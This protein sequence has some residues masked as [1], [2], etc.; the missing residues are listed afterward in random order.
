MYDGLDNLAAG[1]GVWGEGGWNKNVVGGGGRGD[2]YQAFKSTFLKQNIIFEG[3]KSNTGAHTQK[4]VQEW[5]YE[6]LIHTFQPNLRKIVSVEF[7]IFFYPQ[8]IH[9][10][11]IFV[12]L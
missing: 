4:H 11:E 5:K 12:A 3:D 1:G 7:V 6:N 2:V 9:P 8:K 10:R